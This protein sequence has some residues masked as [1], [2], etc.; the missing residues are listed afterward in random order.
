MYN[1]RSIASSV[2]MRYEKRH[3]TGHDDADETRI[4]RKVNN[5][6]CKKTTELTL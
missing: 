2:Q 1:V 4:M 5:R 3:R 6:R